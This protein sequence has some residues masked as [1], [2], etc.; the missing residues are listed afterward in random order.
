MVVGQKG[1]DDR[2]TAL[3]DPRASVEGLE[4]PKV[5]LVGDI[6]LAVPASAGGGSVAC[7]TSGCRRSGLLDA[8]CVVLDHRFDRTPGELRWLPTALEVCAS[9]RIEEGRPPL[10]P[11]RHLPLALVYEPMVMGT[12]QDRIAQA[13]LPPIGP[14]SEVMGVREAHATAREPASTV[15]KVERPA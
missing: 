11:P 2:P 9:P 7:R 10:A 3:T 4:R 15:A 5:D 14:M 12:E 8:S 1:L 13:R 6:G